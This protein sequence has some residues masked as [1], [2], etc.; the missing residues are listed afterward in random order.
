MIHPESKLR[1]RLGIPDSVQCCV[2]CHDEFD[3]GMSSP[4]EIEING[5]VYHCCCRVHEY[6]NKVISISNYEREMTEEG[7]PQIIRDVARRQMLAV[8]A[9]TRQMAVPE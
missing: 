7:I 4:E 3:H 5:D 1:E 6:A 8:E 9:R 2:S